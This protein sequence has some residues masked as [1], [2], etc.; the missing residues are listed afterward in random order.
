MQQDLLPPP[1]TLEPR[2]KR[3]ELAVP[4]CLRRRMLEV[5]A[6]FDVS[7]NEVLVQCLIHGLSD[8]LVVR[9]IERA[10]L[11]KRQLA[12]AQLLPVENSSHFFLLPASV[13]LHLNELKAQHDLRFTEI[14]AVCLQHG[15]FDHLVL[16]RIRLLAA[17]RTKKIGRTVRKE[18]LHRAA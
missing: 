11:H 16:H 2:S 5:A 13:K 4:S 7:A 9:L 14:V 10:A 17:S 18:D 12:G 1:P 6:Q 8:D 3:S 15:L